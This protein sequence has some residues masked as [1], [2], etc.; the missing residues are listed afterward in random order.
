[1]LLGESSEGENGPSSSSSF[2][3]DNQKESVFDLL[4]IL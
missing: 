4:N 2:Y 3:S 1:M